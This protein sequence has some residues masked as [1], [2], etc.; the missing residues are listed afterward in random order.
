MRLCRNYLMRTPGE[1]TN[2]LTAFSAVRP[3]AAACPPREDSRTPIASS[4]EN[5]TVSTAISGSSIDPSLPGTDERA[6]QRV[7]ANAPDWMPPD[8]PLLIV[9]PHPDDEILGAGG[10]IHTWKKLGRIVTVISV[11]DGEAAYPQWRRLGRI[12]REGLR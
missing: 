1:S 3:M 4:P 6:W 11:T 2:R 9:S 10:L 12:R 7:L 5:E 8:G